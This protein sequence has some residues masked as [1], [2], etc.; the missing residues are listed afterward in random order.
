MADEKVFV[1]NPDIEDF[2]VKYDINGDGNPVTFTIRSLES[3][4]FEPVIAEHIIKHLATH[5]LHKRGVR[6]NPELDLKNIR[7]ELE[8]ISD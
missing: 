2:S 6:H 3:E 7:K 4:P 1:F 8:V 5:L